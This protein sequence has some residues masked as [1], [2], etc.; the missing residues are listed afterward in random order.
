MSIRGSE[1]QYP[2]RRLFQGRLCPT[3]F[4]VHDGEGRAPCLRHEILDPAPFIWYFTMESVTAAI[5][6]CLPSMQIHVS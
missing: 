1:F 4:A 5:E 6:A 2:Y 3:D